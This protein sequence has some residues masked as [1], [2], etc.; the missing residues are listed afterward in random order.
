MSQ[1]SK[2]FRSVKV[3]KTL[4]HTS[5]V[6]L[7][8]VHVSIEFFSFP[9]LL[10]LHNHNLCYTSVSVSNYTYITLFVPI[11]DDNTAQT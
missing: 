11:D 7:F 3:K 6:V 5:C 8:C 2:M 10:H 9:W 4:K 1:T